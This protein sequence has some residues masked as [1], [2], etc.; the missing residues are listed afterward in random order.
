MQLKEK[1]EKIKCQNEA[2]VEQLK[3]A[4]RNNIGFFEK[5]YNILFRKRLSE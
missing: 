5:I 3:N 1:F 2:L 4:P